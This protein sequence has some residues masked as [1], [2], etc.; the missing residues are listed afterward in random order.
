[1]DAAIKT[2]R[3]AQLVKSLDSN[4]P[5]ATSYGEIDIADPGTQSS[6]SDTQ[7]YVNNV[8][9]SVDMWTLNIYRGNTFGT[10]FEQWRAI[11]SK[12]MLLGEFGTDTFRTVNPLQHPPVGSVDGLMQSNWEVREWN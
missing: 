8:C 9:P 4:H 10:L 1:M 3:A 11:S 12:P 6:L 2:E 5:V 7:N